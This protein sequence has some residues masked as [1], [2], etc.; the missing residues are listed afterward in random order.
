ML[1]GGSHADDDKNRRCQ[2]TYCMQDVRGALLARPLVHRVR[3]DAVAGCLE[4]DRDHDDPMVLTGLL[5]QSLRGWEIAGN[6]ETIMISPTSEPSDGCA[7]HSSNDAEQRHQGRQAVDGISRDQE[8]QLN[9]AVENQGS[10][11]HSLRSAVRFDPEKVAVATVTSDRDTTVFVVCLEPAQELAPHPAPAELTL[12]VIEGGPVITVADVSR[13]TAPGD[14]LI[15]AADALHSLR[16]GPERAVVV[17][18]LHG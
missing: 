2:C 4:V 10:G 7:S 8:D 17:G 13:T 1:E 6:G 9:H 3:M 15:V 11:T 14:V 16:G 12:V 18:V 5:R